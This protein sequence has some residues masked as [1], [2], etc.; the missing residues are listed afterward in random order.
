[1]PD[2]FLWNIERKECMFAEGNTSRSRRCL[3]GGYICLLSGSEIG[4]R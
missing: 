2:L 4:E 3:N 1:M